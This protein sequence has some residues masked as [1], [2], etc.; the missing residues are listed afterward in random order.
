LGVDAG[1]ALRPDLERLARYSYTEEHIRQHREFARRLYKNY[2]L[3]RP[4]RK[5]MVGWP[6]EPGPE[7]LS[8][9]VY[10]YDLTNILGIE[11]IQD[12]DVELNT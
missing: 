8:R 10:S 9:R 3:D 5:T 1:R 7:R 12:V 6:K 11:E 2:V 4:R